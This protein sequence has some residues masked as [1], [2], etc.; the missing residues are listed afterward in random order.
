M[1]ISPHEII[2]PHIPPSFGHLEVR[3][4][5]IADNQDT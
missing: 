5:P 2:F 4:I 3:N 1:P